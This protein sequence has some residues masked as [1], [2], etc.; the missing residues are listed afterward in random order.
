MAAI[1]VWYTIGILCLDVVE[2]WMA[3]PGIFEVDLFKL[4]WSVDD[5][6]FMQSSI[7]REE[8]NKAYVLSHG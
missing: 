2:V 5:T 1:A 7:A 4:G 8:I 6:R 3:S